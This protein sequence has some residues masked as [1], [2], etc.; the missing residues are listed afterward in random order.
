M[1]MSAVKAE[2]LSKLV[3]LAADVAVGDPT[4]AATYM[5]P[6]INESAYEAYQ[7]TSASWSDGHILVGGETLPRR[8]GLFRRADGGG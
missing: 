6:I 4:E 7:A 5:G 2:F 1:S 8:Q 3:D